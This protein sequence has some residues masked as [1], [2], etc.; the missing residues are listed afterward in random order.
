MKFS[1]E[2]IMLGKCLLHRC[3]AHE[4]QFN[5]TGADDDVFELAITPIVEKKEERSRWNRTCD[6]L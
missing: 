2:Q 6:M 5:F 3:T 4:V 1:T